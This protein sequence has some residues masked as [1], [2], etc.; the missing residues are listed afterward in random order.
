MTIQNAAAQLEKM[1]NRWASDVV[2][3]PP[4]SLID[5]C[6]AI[7]NDLASTTTDTP[8]HYDG[9]SMQVQSLLRHVIAETVRS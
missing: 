5:L 4:V 9:S 3:N 2:R 1:I 8:P 7:L 6:R